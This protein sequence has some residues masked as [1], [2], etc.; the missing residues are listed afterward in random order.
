[1][2]SRDD[3]YLDL[4]LD[5]D[6]DVDHADRVDQVER[7]AVGDCRRH[8]RSGCFTPCA[9]RCSAAAITACSHCLVAA[10][11]AR[12]TRPPLLWWDCNSWRPAGG[13]SDLLDMAVG[14]PATRG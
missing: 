5:L 8:G 11:R 1:M 13:G 12:A 14:P 10:L 7:S 9:S 4:D 3:P 2:F 6:L